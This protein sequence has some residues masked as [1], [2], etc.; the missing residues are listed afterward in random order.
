MSKVMAIDIETANYS[1]EVG[2]WGNTHMFEPTVV[3]TWDGKEAHVFHKGDL[4]D[5]QLRNSDFY[6][7]THHELHPRNLGLHLKKHVDEGGIIVGHNIR[8]FDL[9]VLRD[10]LDMHYAGVLLSKALKGQ[11]TVVDTS[12]SVR[13]VTGKSHHLDSLCKHTLGKGKEIM[14]STDAPL[15]WKEGRH[16]EVIKYCIAD[17]QLNYDLFLHGR[18]EGFVKG[19]NEETGIVEEYHIGW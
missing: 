13:S 16:A 7:V 8:G 9:P 6:G 19:R 4:T 18:N 10:A 17:C 5:N 12:W 3:A 2:G 15:A 14:N 11:E 1:H